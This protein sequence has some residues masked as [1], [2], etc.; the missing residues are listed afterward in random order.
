MIKEI[1][2]ENFTSIPDAIAAGANRIS[3]KDNYVGQGTTVSKGVMKKAIE[4][5]HKY[6][7]TVCCCIRPRVGNFV[8][9]DDEIEIMVDDIRTAKELGADF[10]D[11]GC[12]NEDNTL[13]IPNMKILALA[14]GNMKK[15]CHMAFDEIPKT[16]HKETIDAL[17]SMEFCAILTHGGKIT[18]P[19]NLKQ[20]KE[21]IILVNKRMTVIPGG[22][23]NWK[24]CQDIATELGVSEVHGSKIVELK[25][26]AP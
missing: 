17:A 2:V 19:I 18:A 13:D 9:D 6:N 21:T 24:N 8:F 20:I 4:Y 12:L 7:V 22:G 15:V 5:A 1:C 3:L 23:V 11:F 10:V 26:I 14:A 16:L 25:C